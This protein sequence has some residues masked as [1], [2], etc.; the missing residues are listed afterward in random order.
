MKT[1]HKIIGISILFGILFWIG[2]AILDYIVFFDDTLLEVMITDVSPF[3]IYLRSL[4]FV[5]FL[6]FG[7]IIS[8]F[9][10]KRKQVEKALQETNQMK[11][12]LLD[13]I[14]HDIRNPAGNIYNVAATMLEEQPDNEMLLIIKGSSDKLVKVMEN[15]TVLAQVTNGEKID[16]KEMNLTEVIQSVAKEYSGRLH[17]SEMTIE[18]DLPAKIMVE[19]NP[20]IADVFSNYISNAIKYASGGKKII[21]DTEESDES[22]TINVKDF[23]TTIAEEHWH[24]IFERTYQIDDNKKGRGLGLSIVKKIAEAH[25][26]E[27]GVKPNEPTGNTF[28]IKF[29]ILQSL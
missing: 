8:T 9:I 12:L 21:I 11:E 5:L 15:A 22:L 10:T 16:M 17:R 3:E 14:T 29:S 13:I 6:T 27:V 28:Y 7:T 1:E 18:L 24:K 2:D 25:H 20:I 23:G 19:A 4:V 26:A